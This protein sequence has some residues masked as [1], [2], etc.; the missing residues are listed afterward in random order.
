MAV[1]SSW[2]TNT[3]WPRH[4]DPMNT[5]S[6]KHASMML[7]QN[8]HHFINQPFSCTRLIHKSHYVIMIT[9]QNIRKP[10][11]KNLSWLT[12]LIGLSKRQIRQSK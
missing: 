11:F 5:L 3:R 6:S 8:D 1:R 9:H 4:T 7:Q 10:L 12:I 2:E